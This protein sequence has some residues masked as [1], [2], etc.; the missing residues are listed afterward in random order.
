MR[1]SLSIASEG[2]HCQKTENLEQ[3]LQI[4]G[5]LKQPVRKRLMAE[6]WNSTLYFQQSSCK[7]SIRLNWIK[8]HLVATPC[9]VHFAL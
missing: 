1:N 6:I 3:I 7:H 4:K 5:G 2:F 9:F 8:Y